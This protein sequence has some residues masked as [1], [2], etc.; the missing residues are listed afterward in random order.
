MSKNDVNTMNMDHVTIPDPTVGGGVANDVQAMIVV[1]DSDDKLV[2]TGNDWVYR[3]TGTWH[4]N[5]LFATGESE[6]YGKDYNIFYNTDTQNYVLA[7]KSM[8][9]GTTPSFL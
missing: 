1:G 9:N 7:L 8:D 5:G 3:G 4:P 6:L 2:L